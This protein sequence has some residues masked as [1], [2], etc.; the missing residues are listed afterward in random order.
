MASQEP[1]KAHLRVYDDFL[2][3]YVCVFVVCACVHRV[4]CT[5]MPARTHVLY[6]MYSRAFGGF[7]IKTRVVYTHTTLIVVLHMLLHLDT[8]AQ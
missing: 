7:V 6:R 5:H 3:V 1:K 2:F 8:L 4:G